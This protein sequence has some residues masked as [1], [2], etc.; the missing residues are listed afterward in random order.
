LTATTTAKQGY[1]NID[2][3]KRF[4]ASGEIEWQWWWLIGGGDG[5]GVVQ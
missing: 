2:L 5:G 1:D 3:W 4:A